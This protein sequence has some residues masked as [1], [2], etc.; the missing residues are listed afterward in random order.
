[1]IFLSFCKAS[2]MPPASTKEWHKSIAFLGK[3]CGRKE[4]RNWPPALHL[5]LLIVGWEPCKSS[6]LER[7]QRTTRTLTSNTSYIVSVFITSGVVVVLLGF[8]SQPHH[9]W[10]LTLHD[11]PYPCLEATADLS[12]SPDQDIRLEPGHCPMVLMKSLISNNVHIYIYNVI[13]YV[14]R[15]F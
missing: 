7:Y 3:T 8:I 2:P 4:H 9:P 5:F 6:W 14:F 12:P 10:W 13:I 1:M 15:C 11:C